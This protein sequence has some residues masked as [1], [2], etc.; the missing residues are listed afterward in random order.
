MFRPLSNVTDSQPMLQ[1]ELS[2]KVEHV[3]Y[4][5]YRQPALYD[6]NL[7]LA[8]GESLALIGPSGCG[9]STLLKCI[10]GLL[11]PSKGSIQ[12]AGQDL[13]TLSDRARRRLR[14]KNF[15]FVLQFGM[16][17]PELTLRENAMIP[18]LL[19]ETDRRTARD[20]ASELLGTVGIA[21]LADRLPTEVSGGERQRAAI[22]RALV[23]RPSLV[24]ADEPTGALDSHNADL[25]LSLLVEAAISRGSAVLVV[26]HD[27]A[28]L[29]LFDRVIRM[30]DGVCPVLAED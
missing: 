16:L 22:A 7:E 15:G 25:V 27:N 19:R 1:S 24:L 9:K 13:A 26:T 18:A 5:Y 28:R 17:I 12:V 20:E 3:A 10:A 4:G 29:A 8:K 23:G 30:V 14:A 11:V 21:H 2:L 6:A